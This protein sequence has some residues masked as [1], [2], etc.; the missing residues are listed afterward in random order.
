MK[1]KLDLSVYLVAGPADCAG[2][3]LLQT[4][5]D[6]VAG[7]VT[8]VQLRDKTLPD[9]DFIA[10]G[11]RLK[12]ALADSGVPLIVNDRVEAAL[13]IGAHGIHVGGNDMPA[14][15]VRSLAGDGMI[16][17]TSVVR[18]DPATLP[19]PAIAD[20][21][22]I[23]P[24]FATST[25]PNHDPPIGFD[26]LARLCAAS[27][28]PAVAIGGLKPDH[29]KNAIRAGARGVCVVSAICAAPSPR[30]AAQTIANRVRSARS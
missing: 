21:V 22:G 6:A 15:R 9:A 28:V 11:R 23:G 14:L 3:D 16:I 27:A 29:T 17:G 5:T 10:L 26:G 4:V 7:G 2:G 30:L 24:V 18:A 13:E 25:K 20:Y 12:Q 1:P 19:D 8:V